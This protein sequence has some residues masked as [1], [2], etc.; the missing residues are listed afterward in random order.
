MALKLTDNAREAIRVPQSSPVIVLKIDGISTLFGNV[1]IKEFIR[2]GP[3]LIIG[4]FIIGGFD[5]IEDQNNYIQYDR[6]TTTRITQKLDQSRGQGS[7]ISAMTLNIV[8]FFETITELVSPGFRVTDVLN[9]RVTVFLGSQETSWPEDYNVIFRGV[10]SGINGG[11]GFVE[12]QLNNTDEK[13][14]VTVLPR[15]VSETVT[16]VNFR[17]STF[18]DLL[19]KNRADL[20]NLVQVTYAPGGTAG[21][22]IVS[23]LSTYH[24]Q[25]LIQDGVSTASQIRS[26]IENS[27]FSNQLVEVEITGDGGAA[28]F[29]GTTTLG[30]DSVV[31][32]LSTAGFYSPADMGTLR[33]YA[34]IDDE[35]IEYTGIAMNDLTGAIRG[36]GLNGLAQFHETEA[37][38]EQVLRLFGNGIDLA[39]KLMLSR[40]PE[41]YAENLE[42]DSIVSLAGNPDQPNTIFFQ[43]IDVEVDHG[44]AIGDFVNI[45]DSLVPANNVIGS[46]VLEVG[47]VDNGT[48]VVLSDDLFP[49][50]ASPARA[51]FKS[52]YNV[53]PIGMAMKPNE[54]DVAEHQFVRDTFLPTFNLDIYTKEITDGKGFLE[55]EIYLPMTCFSVPRKG[56][57]SIVYTVGPLPTYEVVTLDTS[58]IENPAQLKTS[59]SV[60]ENFFNSVRFDYEFDPTNNQFTR[61]REIDA[62]ESTVE[63][64]E[65]KQFIVQSKGLR[66]DS[67]ANALIDRAARRF[68]RRYQNGAVAIK[69]AK[70][71]FSKGFQ[72]EIGDVVAVDFA[73]LKLSDFESGN[74]NGALKLMDIQNK[75]LDYKSGDVTV[76]LLDTIFGT[77]DRYGLI[78]PASYTA[79]GSTTTK[80]R[81]KKSFATRDFQRESLKWNGYEGQSVIVRPVDFSEGPYETTIVGFDNED[82]Q[83]M[84]I[85]PPIPVAPGEDWVVEAINYPNDPNPNF[86]AFWKQRHAFFSP[87]VP[88]LA[89]VSN[90]RFTVANANVFRFF[91]GSIV[92]VHNYDYSIDSPERTVIDIIGDDIIVNESLGFIPDNTQ[93]VD[94]IGFPDQTQAYRI[95]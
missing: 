40:G 79:L 28:Q 17:S 47:R 88:V 31:S 16:P 8:D 30:V 94:L 73:S 48:Y 5:V 52:Q 9:R 58:S 24:I 83:G 82:P 4:E 60:N 91:I 43:G 56:R 54:V 57:S 35:L 21:S 74:R 23:L 42:I 36:Q 44:V 3:E 55:K 93:F 68:N 26:A 6:G 53:L 80:L 12:L 84:S 41:F 66:V 20:T 89:G 70:V 39:L 34:Q 22:E 37:G 19:Y 11:A 85:N 46:R 51:S 15:V 81:L 14:R 67:D 69:G 38:V 7:S 49:E 95:V 18:Q 75:V 50:S 90:V 2:I 71:I 32:L 76:D 1:A 72:L 61:S 64:V 78:S 25:V 63:G 86:Q 65:K 45:I 59:R 33:P 92:R 10:V 29:I 62:E 87:Q 77:G 27:P 13:K